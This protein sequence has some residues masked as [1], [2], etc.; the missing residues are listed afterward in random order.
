MHS[1]WRLYLKSEINGN[2]KI[3][4]HLWSGLPFERFLGV[5][6]SALVSI[7]PKVN[8]LLFLP[9]CFLKVPAGALA[10]S[11]VVALQPLRFR[12]DPKP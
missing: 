11:G 3:V 7:N 9:D 6:T 12:S 2:P 8:D 4:F 1:L 5:V 10:T